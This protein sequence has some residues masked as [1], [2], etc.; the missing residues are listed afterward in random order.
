MSQEQYLTISKK[1]KKKAK[2][3]RKDSGS[4]GN[5][6]GH[7]IP[8]NQS[9]ETL[10]SGIIDSIDYA[11]PNHEHNGYYSVGAL[12]M[13]NVQECKYPLTAN[14]SSLHRLHRYPQL[15]EDVKLINAALPK[16]DQTECYPI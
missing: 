2:K 4:P 11:I 15:I 16:I 12:C 7:H 13:P 5:D 1:R 3:H 10:T 6:I 8:V 14:T 9:G